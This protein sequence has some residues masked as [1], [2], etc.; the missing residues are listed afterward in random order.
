ITPW[1]EANV[2][3]WGKNVGNLWR[4]S[5]DITPQWSRLL[6]NFDST[7]SRSL[8]AQPGAWNDPDMLFVGTGDF[9]ENHLTEARSHFS[10]WA[11]VNA[12]LLIG[13]DL[14]KAP[15]ALLDIWGNADVVAINQD[16]GGHQGV[17]AYQS[18]DLQIIV[19]TLSDRGRKAVAIFNRG[20]TPVKATLTAEHLKFSK[21][22]PIG[23]RDLWTKQTLPAFSGSRDFDVAPR[24]TVLLMA[25]G[26]PE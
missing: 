9:D 4:T 18:N 7:A 19:K 20:L 26:Q 25:Q 12:P 16:K 6:H 3:S 8:Y 10:L 13:Y 14:R 24:E 15:T 21:T 2:R 1:G 5:G 11:I 22:A 23:L 17:L